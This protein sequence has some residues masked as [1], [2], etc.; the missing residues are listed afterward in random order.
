VAVAAG[1]VPVLEV[2]VAAVLA[3]VVAAAVAAVPSAVVAEEAVPVPAVEGVA[4]AALRLPLVAGAVEEVPHPQS[5]AVA[6]VL[7]HQ[8]RQSVVA[9]VARPHPA[10]AGALP[11]RSRM[12]IV[13]ATPVAAMPSISLVRGTSAAAMRVVVM[14][15]PATD[16]PLPNAIRIVVPVRRRAVALP[17]D[18]RSIFLV[19]M[20]RTSGIAAVRIIA[21]AIAATR[22]NVEIAF[23]ELI[24]VSPL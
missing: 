14:V 17:P 23:R 12:G 4:V 21:A 9:V 5:V 6:E 24:A 2:G 15:P 20:P 3:P 1:V 18:A 19:A 10:E 16:R 8:P 22:A 13:E 11:P 7:L